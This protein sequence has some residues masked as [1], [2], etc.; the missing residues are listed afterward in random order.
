MKT[1]PYLAGSLLLALP[2]L[3]AAQATA[4]YPRYYVGLGLYTSSYQPLGGIYSRGI[5][6]PV[7]LTVGYQLRPRLAVQASVAYSSSNTNYSGLGKYYSGSAAAASPYAYFMY[8]GTS[9]YRTTSTT[10]LARYA[11]T[12]QA[13][14]R[15]QVDVLGGFTLVNRYSSLSGVRTDSD[16]TNVIVATSNYGYSGKQTD[17]LLAVGAGAR[18]RFGRQ[19]EA[20][21]D[22]TL[23]RNLSA[24]RFMGYATSLGLRY[25]FGGLR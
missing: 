3:G 7:Q 6:V 22:V 15:F 14:H 16:S 24:A 2:L 8:D 5:T 13:A 9:T 23:N 17:V 18:Y 21:L 19:L 4:P 1:L 10:L 20:L 12:S 11:L 25:R